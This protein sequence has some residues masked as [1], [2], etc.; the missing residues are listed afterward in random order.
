MLN[1]QKKL[2]EL[3]NAGFSFEVYNGEEAMFCGTRGSTIIIRPFA[4]GSNLAF[5]YRRSESKFKGDSVNIY[6]GIGIST[7]DLITEGNEN[8]KLKGSFFNVFREFD[9]KTVFIVPIFNFLGA[10]FAPANNRRRRFSS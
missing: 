7:I 10:A 9:N 8:G 6:S 3:V 2:R 1:K 4:S 5:R